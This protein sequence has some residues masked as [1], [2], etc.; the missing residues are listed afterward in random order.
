[1][2]VQDYI[3]TLFC[4]DE[5]ADVV[6]EFVERLVSAWAQSYRHTS[7]SKLTFFFFHLRYNLLFA[8]PETVRRLSTSFWHREFWDHLGNQ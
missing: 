1:M 3:Y 2:F 5:D 7:E 4:K 6:R 8:T